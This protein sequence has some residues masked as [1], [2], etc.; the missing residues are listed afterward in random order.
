MRSDENF[1]L[2]KICAFL[3]D[4]YACIGMRLVSCDMVVEVVLAGL[5]LIPHLIPICFLGREVCVSY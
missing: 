1:F 3:D 2:N 4:G 5:H